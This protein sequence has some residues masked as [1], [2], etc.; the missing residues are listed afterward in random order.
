LRQVARE[1]AKDDHHV[2]DIFVEDLKSTQSIFNKF[3][4][5]IVKLKSMALA[6]SSLGC[7]LGMV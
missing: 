3:G 1:S 2:H 6:K 4:M 5:L 7:N